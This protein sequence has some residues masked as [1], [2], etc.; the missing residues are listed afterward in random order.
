[1]HLP[2]YNVNRSKSTIGVTKSGSARFSSKKRRRPRCINRVRFSNVVTV[3][4][5]LSHREYT[6]D[7]R[8]AVWYTRFEYFYF[9]VSEK[10]PKLSILLLKQ[11]MASRFILKQQMASRFIWNAAGVQG[12][13]KYII[14]LR[15]SNYGMHGMQVLQI[16]SGDT[17]TSNTYYRSKIHVQINLLFLYIIFMGLLMFYM[18]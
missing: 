11:Q 14:F 3:R 12:W 5:V 8:A 17:L 15:I 1:M 9:K 16:N 7:E 6:L 10:H 2:K 18:L 13:L 4:E